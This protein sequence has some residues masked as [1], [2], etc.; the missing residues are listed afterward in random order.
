MYQVSFR[1]REREMY[2]CMY[3]YI[4]KP[5]YLAACDAVVISGASAWGHYV[6]GH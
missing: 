1:E 5:K 4:Y 6:N 2:I 3:V